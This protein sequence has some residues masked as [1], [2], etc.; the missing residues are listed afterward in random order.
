MY[1][2]DTPNL[3]Y[4]VLYVIRYMDVGRPWGIFDD[5]GTD[6]IIILM[7]NHYNYSDSENWTETQKVNEAQ[8]S[9]RGRVTK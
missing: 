7:K 3:L 2:N 1:T 5:D 8:R 4:Y 9:S 6:I